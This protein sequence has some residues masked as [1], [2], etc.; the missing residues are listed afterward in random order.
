M[1]PMYWSTGVQYSAF[2]LSNK[3]L[4]FVLSQYLKKYQ[5]LSTKVSIV[6]VSLFA[7]ELQFGQVVLMKEL[8]V[9]NGLP[10]GVNLTSLGNAT[11]RALSGTGTVPQCLQ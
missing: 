4:L 1:P 8:E 11:G 7:G 9:A 3:A 10:D 2:F 5:L 6:S